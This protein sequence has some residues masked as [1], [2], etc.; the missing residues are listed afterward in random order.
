MKIEMISFLKN[1]SSLL[2]ILLSDPLLTLRLL[3]YSRSK[4]F[5]RFLFE[6]T[7][8]AQILERYRNIYSGGGSSGSPVFVK[9]SS[10]RNILFSLPLTGILEYNGLNIYQSD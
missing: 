2:K 10:D 5:F 7:N 8:R 4:N 1:I 6:N 3:T 9:N